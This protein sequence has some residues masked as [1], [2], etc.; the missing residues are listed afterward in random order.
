MIHAH[1]STKPELG[2]SWSTIVVCYWQLML[3][4]SLTN[5]KYHSLFIAAIDVVDI[6]VIGEYDESEKL[7]NC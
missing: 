4:S 6:A 2:T 1:N 3:K 5:G 7:C